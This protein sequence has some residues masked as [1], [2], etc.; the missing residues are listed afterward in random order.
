MN[1]DDDDDDYYW[2]GLGLPPSLIAIGAAAPS[3][4]A[5]PGPRRQLLGVVPSSPN[6]APKRLQCPAGTH[7]H[8]TWRSSS[9]NNLD[10]KLGD[11][12]ASAKTR[13]LGRDGLIRLKKTVQETWS[14]CSPQRR[15]SRCVG[16]S[17][18]TRG[19]YSRRHDPLM[20]QTRWGRSFGLRR[21]IST[22]GPGSTSFGGRF[23]SSERR[24]ST[25]H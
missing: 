5:S 13:R 4:I 23:G 24:A 16:M 9:K 15:I 20:S 2:E 14:S 11:L 1:D 21:A 10:F 25:G 6:C 18:P 3:S 19:M 12:G 17:G 22:L 8:H 7:T